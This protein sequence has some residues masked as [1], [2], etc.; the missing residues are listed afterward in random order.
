MHGII[1]HASVNVHLLNSKC[2]S[3]IV[4]L[5]SNPHPIYMIAS[6]VLCVI[7]NPRENNF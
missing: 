3:L 7:S 4:T 2:D 6:C 1:L 5:T